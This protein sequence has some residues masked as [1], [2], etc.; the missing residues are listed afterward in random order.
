MIIAAVSL[1]SCGNAKASGNN[2]NDN[3]VKARVKECYFS[4][5][6]YK[7]EPLSVI[8]IQYVDPMYKAGDRYEF[9]GKTFYIDSVLYNNDEQCPYELGECPNPKCS[10]YHS[11]TLLRDYQLY[12]HDDT[13]IVYDGKRR[14]DTYLSTWNSQLD[15]IILEDN[16]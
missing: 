5:V 9:A 1:Q 8:I 13:V 10:N 14:V 6:T 12:L 3:K 15:S 4:E 11:N 16:Q 7:Y 2:I